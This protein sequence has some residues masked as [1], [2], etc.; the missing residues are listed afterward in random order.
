MA[1]HPIWLAICYF[2]NRYFEINGVIFKKIF[3]FILC[4]KPLHYY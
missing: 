4:G 2:Y 1:R 3:I